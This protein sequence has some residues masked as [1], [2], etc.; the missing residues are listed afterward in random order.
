M[1]TFAFVDFGMCRQVFT[2]ELEV[3][4]FA[5]PEQLWID[6][7]GIEPKPE[8]GW[9]WDGEEFIQPPPAYVDPR[10]AILAE[11]DQIDRDSARPLRVLIITN[12]DIGADT[13]ER[14]ELEALELR[15]A[16]L[17]SQLDTLPPAP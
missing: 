9:T 3:E 6:V 16:D 7:T 8:W 15:A 14:A 12:P 4:Q 5:P 2:T 10:P 17:R 13:P 1:K 11:L